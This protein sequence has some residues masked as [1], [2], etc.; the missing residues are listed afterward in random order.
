MHL[1]LYLHSWLA[2][3]QHWPRCLLMLQSGIALAFSTWMKEEY[4]KS[5]LIGWEKQPTFFPFTFSSFCIS[6][7]SCSSS[8]THC[9]DILWI[10]GG[11]FLT[12]VLR[13]S[14]EWLTFLNLI[15]LHILVLDMFSLFSLTRRRK[16][17]LM[18]VASKLC[19]PVAPHVALC[20]RL[21]T[22]FT[23]CF[24]FHAK[25]LSANCGLNKNRREFRYWESLVSA[26]AGSR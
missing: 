3:T 10:N 25:D 13:G 7:F 20:I 24:S 5:L 11:N 4:F 9:L 16:Q 12:S 17:T 6:F 18:Q 21:G 8:K 15:L 23:Y 2:G 26:E 19:L 22:D 14:Q 1:I